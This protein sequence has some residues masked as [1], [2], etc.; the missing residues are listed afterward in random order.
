M[1]RKAESRRTEARWEQEEPMR[2]VV[3]VRIGKTG[4]V[5]VHIEVVMVGL[6]SKPLYNSSYMYSSFLFSIN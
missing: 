4:E 5:V 2:R 6:A 3:V 1:E